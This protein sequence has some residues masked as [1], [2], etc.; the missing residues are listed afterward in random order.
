MTS[1]N[2]CTQGQGTGEG[3][4]CTHAVPSSGG[5]GGGD[6]APMGRFSLK[7]PRDS[8]EHQEESE[9]TVTQLKYMAEQDTLR[10]G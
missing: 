10:W 3:P 7:S 1:Q 5:V 8:S 6:T 4:V 9:I 2:L